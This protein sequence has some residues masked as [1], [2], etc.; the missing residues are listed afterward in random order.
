MSSNWKQAQK[1]LRI[2]LALI[3]IVLS[4][5]NIYGLLKNREDR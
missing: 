3:T 4:V 1:V 5:I 2:I